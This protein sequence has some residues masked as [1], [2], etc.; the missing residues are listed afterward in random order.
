MSKLKPQVSEFSMVGQLLGLVMKGKDKIKYLRITVSEQEYWIKLSKKFQHNFDSAITPGCWIEV[1]GKR[2]H[3]LKTGKV[4]LKANLVR[5]AFNSSPE[6]NLTEVSKPTP[7]PLAKILLCKKAKCWKRG[8]KK[9][10]QVLEESL[11]DRG[12]AKQVQIKT[13]GCL[14]QCKKAP[15]LILMPS[16]NRYHKVKP[17]QIP[18]LIDEHFSGA[19]V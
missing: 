14:K 1:K 17:Q 8:G 11:R 18:A 4:K 5:N 12:L 19:L 16:K 13:T 9:I 3:S 2:K 10:S 15:N 7:C 6:K